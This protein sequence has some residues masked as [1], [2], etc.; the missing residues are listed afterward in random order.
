VFDSPS[1]GVDCGLE[2]CEALRG[3]GLEIR[4]GVHAGEVEARDD[5][6]ISGIAVN[7]AAR[8]EQNATDGEFW[9]SSTVREML[10]GGRSRF[11]DRGEFE[12]KGVAGLR[13]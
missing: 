4:A 8:V 7:L 13:M 11:E 9:A 10:L 3:M 12:L 6:R 5:D 2:P 1:A